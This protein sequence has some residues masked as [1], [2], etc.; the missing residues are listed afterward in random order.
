MSEGV[1][2]DAARPVSVPRASSALLR[3]TNAGLVKATLLA[4]LAPLAIFAFFLQP[5]AAMALGSGVVLVSFLVLRG[6][7]AGGTLAAPLDLK[8]YAGCLATSFALCLLGGE[9]HVFFATWDWFTRDAVL[10]DVVL[11]KLPVLYHYQ[12]GDFF[13]RAALG[14]Y[15]FPAAVGWGF[16]L[17]AAHLALLLQNGFL[18]GSIFYLAAA[19]ASGAKRR[20]LALVIFF[21]PVDVIPHIAG[22]YLFQPEFVIQPHF[23][24]WNRLLWHWAQLPQLFWAPNHA[25]PGWMIATLL[26]LHIRR[27]IDGALLALSSIVLLFWSPLVMIGAAPLLLLR[28]VASLSPDLLRRRTVLAVL[29]SVFLLPLLI[30]LSLDAAA[31]SR[32]WLFEKKG[33]FIW[34]PLALIFGLPHVWLLLWSRDALPP[35]LKP[36]FGVVAAT[37]IFFPL[38]R[39]GVTDIDKDMTMRAMLAP[40]FLLGFMFAEAAPI[41]VESAGLRAKLT[42]AIVLLSAVTGL[43]ELRRAVTDP[44]YRIND[45]NLLTAT[46]KVV[47]GFPASNYLA[48]VEKAPAW[49]TSTAGPRLQIEQRQCWPN[50]PFTPDREQQ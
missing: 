29:A 18:F 37:L 44:P 27:E 25:F 2:W 26:L 17:E 4:A 36:T 39:F 5:V 28:G 3:A 32:G 21:G 10:S 47:P 6:W 30:Y 38:Y 45:C 19:L 9:Y 40:M 20:L 22:S 50:Y 8:L 48:R 34:Y 16:G 11:N 7:T 31:L 15:M 46:S 12:G 33:F 35:W 42:T 43:M 24:Y 23:M 1:Y 41:L 49:L 13:L 14:M